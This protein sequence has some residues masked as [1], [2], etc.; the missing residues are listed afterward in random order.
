M[1]DCA[2]NFKIFSCMIGSLISCKNI[3][4]V[5]QS[6]GMSRAIHIKKWYI[7]YGQRNVG[8]SAFVCK[9][10]WEFFFYT[11]GFVA[12]A[13]ILMFGFCC[14]SVSWYRGYSSLL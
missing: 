14:F 1:P 12:G 13:L 5:S 8:V 2:K 9:N 10:V 3:L 6:I 11:L 4:N 7:V